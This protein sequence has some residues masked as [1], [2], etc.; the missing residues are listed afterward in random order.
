MWCLRGFQRGR[1][2]RRNPAKPRFLQ[3]SRHEVVWMAQPG[4]SNS[5]WS[6]KLG[7]QMKMGIFQSITVFVTESGWGSQ[8]GRGSW[9]EPASFRPHTCLQ[10]REPWGPGLH[11]SERGTRKQTWP[12][13][14]WPPVA[15]AT[16]AS[17]V[18]SSV[19]LGWTS[20][21]E[22]RSLTNTH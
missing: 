16:R 2:E 8:W 5:E 4:L 12:T 11:S 1:R 7:E 13:E 6:W 19:F 14:G 18:S 21:S 9:E 15:R 22:S 10:L 20:F 17:S 3:I